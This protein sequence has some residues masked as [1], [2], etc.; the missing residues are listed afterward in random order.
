MQ[1]PSITSQV[2]NNQAELH[3]GLKFRKF[4]EMTRFKY[5]NYDVSW[6]KTQPK[7][8]KRIGIG[9]CSQK[10]DKGFKACVGS[11]GLREFDDGMYSASV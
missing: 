8:P 4:F 3:S 2:K 1:C 9:L 11:S 6:V 7:L 5:H 10:I